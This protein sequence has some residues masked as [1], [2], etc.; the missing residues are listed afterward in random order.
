MKNELKFGLV[1]IGGLMCATESLAVTFDLNCLVES[2]VCTDKNYEYGSITIIDSL[3]KSN[4]VDITIDIA[5]AGTKP[6]ELY[7]NIDPALA[8][9]IESGIADGPLKNGAPDTKNL[10]TYFLAMRGT[11]ELGVAFDEDSLGSPAELTIF[12]VSIPGTGNLGNDP[13]PVTLTLSL[14]LNGILYDLAPADFSFSAS[15]GTQNL[16]A[17]VHIGS[18]GGLLLG[19]ANSIDSIKVGSVEEGGS[20]PGG[21]PVPEPTSVLLVSLGLLGMGLTRRRVHH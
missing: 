19:C 5:G 14:L 21:N 7:L 10:D 9:A 11:K 15:L 2:K 6:L 17:E 4:A 1:L 20:D 18:C 16:F 8:S 3:T 12:D 13:E